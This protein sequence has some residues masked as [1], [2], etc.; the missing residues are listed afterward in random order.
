LLR[1]A[2]L[3]CIEQEERL[4]ELAN[5]GRAL[6]TIQMQGVYMDGGASAAA[7]L[8]GIRTASAQL[9]A[10]LAAMTPRP[11]DAV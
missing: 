11:I 10:W 9:D 3:G 2:E 5:I 4:E 6:R 1:A 7:I 8:D